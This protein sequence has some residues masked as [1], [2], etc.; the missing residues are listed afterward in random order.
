MRKTLPIL[1]IALAS[2]GVF[3]AGQ[4]PEF[5]LG[6]VLVWKSENRGHS[7]DFVIRMAQFRPNRYFEWENQTTQGTVLIRQSALEGARKYTSYRLF[8]AGADMESSDEVSYWLSRNLYNDLRTARKTSIF[9]DG[10]KTDFVLVGS[11]EL[12][13]QVNQE[14]QSLKVLEAKDSRGGRWW[15]L[16][17]PE[18]PLVV[19]RQVSTYQE[20]LFSVSTGRTDSLR[21]IKGSKLKSL[22]SR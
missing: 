3:L 4:L 17:D 22:G 11:G 9:L 15:F 19:K 7:F 6:T 18:N 13:V 16:D 21:W 10:I 8:Q 1:I 2:S 12:V 14:P 5:P 20:L